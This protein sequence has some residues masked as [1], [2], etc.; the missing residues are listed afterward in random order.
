MLLCSDLCRLRPS[1]VSAAFLA[2]I[3]CPRAGGQGGNLRLTDPEDV[4][5]PLLVSHFLG[6]WMTGHAP[7]SKSILAIFME[8]SSD[9]L[10][11]NACFFIAGSLFLSLL[12]GL[13]P[14]AYLTTP[15]HQTEILASPHKTQLFESAGHV[16]A[17]L[18]PHD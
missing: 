5:Q 13:L 3:P 16:S 18:C 12:Y 4:Y 17:P 11:L 8:T 6:T 2:P 15:S 7:S 9:I 14:V 10:S 1:P